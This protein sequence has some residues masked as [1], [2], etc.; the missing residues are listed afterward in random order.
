MYI[1]FHTKVKQFNSIEEMEMLINSG[2]IND[3]VFKCTSEY[4]DRQYIYNNIYNNLRYKCSCQF[5]IKNS[6]ISHDKLGCQKV[7]GSLTKAAV[8]K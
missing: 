3:L 5:V 2:K 8:K 1:A 4:L 6:T 7:S